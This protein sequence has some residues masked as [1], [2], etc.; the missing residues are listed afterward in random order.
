[1]NTKLFK[2]DNRINGTYWCFAPDTQ[3]A[4]KIIT[5]EVFGGKKKALHIEDVTVE[6]L[7]EDGVQ[8]LINNNFVGIPKRLNFM[9]NG[10]MTA[11]IEHYDNKKRSEI[12]W[13]SEKIPGSREIWR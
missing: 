5:K 1:M 7:Q 2:V 3:T 10:S 9:L 6:H 12:L 8:Y 4:S 13:Y 11:M